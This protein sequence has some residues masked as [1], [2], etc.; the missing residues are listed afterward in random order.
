MIL[1]LLHEL[2]V[3]VYVYG[4]MSEVISFVL[5]SA[6]LFLNSVVKIPLDQ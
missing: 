6:I 3:C 2:C 4:V 1:T 5:K